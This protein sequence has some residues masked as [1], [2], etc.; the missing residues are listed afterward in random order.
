MGYCTP[1]HPGISDM[2]AV[3]RR[4]VLVLDEDTIP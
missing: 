1:K 3:K 4:G 2:F